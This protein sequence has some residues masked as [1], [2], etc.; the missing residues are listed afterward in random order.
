MKKLAILLT[1]GFLLA[2]CSDTDK[3]DNS[4]RTDDA[5]PSV[6]DSQSNDTTSESAG[7]EVDLE[8]GLK[9]DSTEVNYVDI[10][11]GDIPSNKKVNFT[12][13]IFE[14]EEGRY[15]LKNDIHD[16]DEDVL[17]IDDIRLGEKTEIPEGTKVNVYGTYS[18]LD[19]Q[20]IPIIKAV[21]I[22]AN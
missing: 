3:S 17:W 4:T 20:N 7:V 8:E 1:A 19:D 6:E 13:T 2:A 21:F 15:G 18:D 22:D 5:T 11:K 10:A 9:A 12:G 14:I 16:A